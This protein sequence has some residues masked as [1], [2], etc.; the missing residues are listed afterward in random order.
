MRLNVKETKWSWNITP[1]KMSKSTMTSSSL[2]LYCRNAST[3]A[4]AFSQAPLCGIPYFDFDNLP[5][6]TLLQIMWPLKGPNGLGMLPHGQG[7]EREL[8]KTKRNGWKCLQQKKM[9][10]TFGLHIICNR[11]NE[12]YQQQYIKAMPS[13]QAHHSWSKEE[14]WCKSNFQLNPQLSHF[15][16]LFT[17]CLICRDTIHT[18]KI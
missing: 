3:N 15:H 6:S 9:S 11:T 1:V 17:Q 14:C 16:V 10:E 2:L 18:M 4:W 7:W 8:Q 12:Q 5:T 13:F